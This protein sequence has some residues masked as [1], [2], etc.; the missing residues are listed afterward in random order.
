MLSALRSQAARCSE[1]EVSLEA[2][3]RKTVVETQPSSDLVTWCYAAVT[4]EAELPGRRL[5]VII[6]SCSFI[7]KS[8]ITVRL[9]LLFNSLHN[10]SCLVES[11]GYD[12]QQ[13]NGASLASPGRLAR[14]GEAKA[15]RAKASYGYLA[16]EAYDPAR[17]SGVGTTQD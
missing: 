15:R 1:T 13:R 3:S 14:L 7:K 8:L 2:V 4:E 12:R 10:S 5:E 11:A 16:R 9:V 6:T 17:R